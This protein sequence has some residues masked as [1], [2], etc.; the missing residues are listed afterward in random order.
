MAEASPTAAGEA[1][2]PPF[3][4]WEKVGQAGEERLWEQ[5]HVWVDGSRYE[6]TGAS[7]TLTMRDYGW[8]SSLPLAGMGCRRCLDPSHHSGLHT[9]F[10]ACWGMIDLEATLSSSE[11]TDMLVPCGIWWQCDGPGPAGQHVQPAPVPRGEHCC[12]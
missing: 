3:I 11:L 8:Q 7:P 1:V 5:A 6:A 10:H 9:S 4:R 12:P 2:P